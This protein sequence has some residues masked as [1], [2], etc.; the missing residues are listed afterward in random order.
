[1]YV[2]VCFNQW[3][4]SELMVVLDKDGGEDP[5]KTNTLFLCFRNSRPSSKVV[6]IWCRI[7]GD[8]PKEYEYKVFKSGETFESAMTKAQAE[9]GTLCPLPAA[10]L[11]FSL[12]DWHEQDPLSPDTGSADLNSP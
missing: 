2:F 6:A 10:Y 1:M 9:F 3:S 7:E 11:L 8:K 12:A 5:S 4:D